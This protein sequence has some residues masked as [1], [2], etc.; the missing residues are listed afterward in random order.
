ML[1]CSA[2][3]SPMTTRRSGI[4]SSVSAAAAAAFRTEM[5]NLQVTLDAGS[6]SSRI[7][8]NVPKA[9]SMGVEW[10]LSATP[11]QGLDLSISGS[12]VS[13]QLDSTLPGVLAATTGIRDGNRLPTVP[14]FQMAAAATYSFPVATGANA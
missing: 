8:F 6:C 1:P 13:A 9:H 3:S 14:N 7:V 10:E 12:V 4:T 2:A 11:V 5:D